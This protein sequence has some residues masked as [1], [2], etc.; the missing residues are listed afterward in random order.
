MSAQA[1][2]ERGISW[3]GLVL[4][5]AAWVINQQ[6]NYAAVPWICAHR[7]YFTPVMAL[8]LAMV[9]LIGSLLSWR[10][11]RV[12]PSGEHNGVGGTP[13]H[14]IAGISAL[15]GVLFAILIL[16]QGAAALILDGCER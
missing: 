3:G 15:L 9:A 13:A 10:T 5:P 16:T 4:G 2:W 11:W 6:G 14:L 7:I 1:I 12:A 8:V